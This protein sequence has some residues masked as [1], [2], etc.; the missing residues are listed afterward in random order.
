MNTY[1][2]RV[3]PKNTFSLQ[4]DVP[5]YYLS[6]CQDKIT[7]TNP[8]TNG[9]INIIKTLKFPLQDFDKSRILLAKL[10]EHQDIV[11][12]IG[13]DESIRKEYEYSK[14]LYKL[15]G[16]VKFICYFECNDDFLSHPSKTRNHLCNGVGSQ[17]KVI[18]MP[19]FELGSIG[20]YSWTNENIKLLRTCIKHAILTYISAFF[21]G[22]LHGD[23][24]P[25]NV[26]LKKTKQT[27]ISYLFDDI[28][29]ISNIETNGI[30]TWIMDFENTRE[31][32][33]NNNADLL[34]FYFDIQKFFILLQD[35]RFIRN[36]DKTSTVPLLQII[37]HYINHFLYPDLNFIHKV[38]HYIENIS[39]LHP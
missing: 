7:N 22:Y 30:R 37:N 4:K 26:L 5:K 23:F 29:E 11:V 12:K 8:N 39:L 17:M 32:N 24:H 19:Y 14:K 15:K 31:I 6:Y 1:N 2:I 35:H 27:S 10:E 9:W 3:L 13:D 20:F 18:I 16:F 21:L 34:D 36:I 33:K 28:G 38:L 25:G